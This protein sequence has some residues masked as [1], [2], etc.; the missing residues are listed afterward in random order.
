MLPDLRDNLSQ[1]EPFLDQQCE[2]W[3]RGTRDEYSKLLRAWQQVYPGNV[4]VYAR[5]K[6]G[7][8]AFAEQ[9]KVHA[10]HFF[11]VQTRDPSIPPRTSG[12]L[13][14]ELWAEGVP[15]FTGL[16]H[17]IDFFVSPEDMSWTMIYTHEVDNFGGPFFTFAEWVVPRE[18]GA[19]Q[20]RR[21]RR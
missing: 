14:Y 16:S 17:H 3:R 21:R 6:R 10:R 11:L 7:V 2:S 4:M 8:R 12:D 13:A 18:S 20:G 1:L 15:D 9:E 19:R 5:G